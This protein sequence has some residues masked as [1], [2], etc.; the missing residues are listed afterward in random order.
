[1]QSYSPVSYDGCP[2]GFSFAV[3]A[4]DAETLLFFVQYTPLWSCALL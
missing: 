4:A 1:M 2:P 3:C